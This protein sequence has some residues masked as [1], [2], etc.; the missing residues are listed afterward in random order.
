MIEDLSAYVIAG[1]VAA[2]QAEDGY[3]TDSRTP[4][5]GIQDGVDAEEIG[6]AR[7]F[8]SE[9]WDIKEASVILSGIAARTREIV[10]GTGLILPATR[11]PWHAAAFAATMQACYGQRIILG[12]GRGDNAI[13]RDMGLKMSTYRELDDYVTIL[14]RL[15]KGETVAYDGPVGTFPG[16]EFSE[17]VPGPPPPVWFGTFA[18][19]KGAEAIAK[20]FDGVMLPP[21]ISP[22]ATAR[23]VARIRE[24]CER[25]GRDP[26]EVRI[27][28]AVITAP[29][30]DEIETRSLAHGRAV[31][32]LQYPGYGEILVEEND[33]EMDTLHHI[34]GH[35]QFAEDDKVADRRYHRHELRAAERVPDEWMHET[36]ALGS[37]DDCVRSL[38]RFRDAGADEIATYGSTPRQNAALA[39]AWAR[40]AQPAATG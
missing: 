4:A 34:R 7:V 16:L 39:Q 23:A 21:V 5:Q 35:E 38:Q 10:V 17:T 11:Q 31:G 19:P 30:L 2:T 24:A 8:L 25:I 15:W 3:P 29:D 28:Q 36:C 12:L 33:W 9:R 14:R 27:S 13:L 20:N 1:A 22:D 37:V 40:R 6:F 18:R 26:A 32:Y